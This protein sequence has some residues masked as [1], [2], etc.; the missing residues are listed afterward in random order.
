MF[1]IARVL[2][3]LDEFEGYSAS[4]PLTSLY[5]REE[6]TVTRDG[7][8]VVNAWVY[9]YNRPLGGAPRIESGDYLEYL[10]MK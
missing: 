7:G 9:F 5:T 3:V 10:R 4:D 2:T 6:T 1:D 8:Q